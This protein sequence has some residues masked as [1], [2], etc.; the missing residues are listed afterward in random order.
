MRLSAQSIGVVVQESQMSQPLKVTPEPK[1]WLH[2]LVARIAR[3]LVKPRLAPS[4]PTVQAL[5]VIWPAKRP[6]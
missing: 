1:T 3:V 2:G 6:S 4:S 5:E